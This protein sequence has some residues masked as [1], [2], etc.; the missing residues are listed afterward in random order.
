MIYYIRHGFSCANLYHDKNLD[1]SK[2]KIAIKK[3]IDAPL[4]DLGIRQSKQLV[5]KLKVDL[6]I[7]SPLLRAIQTAYYMFPGKQIIIC[8]Y[9]IEKQ[10]EIGDKLMSYKRKISILKKK[11]QNVDY[12]LL[13][14]I[15]IEKSSLNKFEKFIGN[16]SNKYNIAVVTHGML[17]KSHFKYAGFYNN[18]CVIKDTGIKIFNGFSNKKH[19]FTRKDVSVCI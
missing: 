12:T 3:Y 15:D 16:L 9:I 10:H 17:L 11:F 4:S 5:N 13:R 8:P 1:M 14:H 7:C 2:I 19:V 6:I 18:N